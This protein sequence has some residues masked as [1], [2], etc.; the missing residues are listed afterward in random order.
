MALSGIQPNGQTDPSKALRYN[1]GKP[2]I[3]QVPRC[4]ITETAKVLT[5]GERKYAKYNWR[6]GGDYSIPYDC[7]MRHM[8][9][10]W[11]GEENDP[12][13]GL[14]HLAHAAANIAFL[15]FYKE[16]GVGID[17]RPVTENLE[18][19]STEEIDPFPTQ[20]SNIQK[21]IDQIEKTFSVE[22][23]F[24]HQWDESIANTIK[25]LSSEDMKFLIH[26]L[27]DS[28]I[29]VE[30]ESEYLEN[31]ERRIFETLIKQGEAEP[32]KEKCLDDQMKAELDQDRKELDQD[33][34]ELDQDRKEL[35]QEIDEII[36]LALKERTEEVANDALL[37]RF[38]RVCNSYLKNEPYHIT[39]PV[40]PDLS[41]VAPKLPKSLRKK[42]L[43]AIAEQPKP[44]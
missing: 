6:K 17:N 9:A 37:N 22:G 20:E 15:L 42:Y 4:L 7:L 16:K 30:S 39:K 26:V 13:S 21:V 43:E 18:K 19:G 29:P 44:E 31:E 8:T 10:W 5:Y 3:H 1:E 40:E 38:A 35:D 2:E 12:E 32:S 23:N 36:K 24:D 41:E 25:S 33:R 27:R 11:E 14:S 28:G 34:K